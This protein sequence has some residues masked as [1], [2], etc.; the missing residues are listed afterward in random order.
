MPW[1]PPESS[2]P[3]CSSAY[4]SAPF[5]IANEN[6]IIWGTALYIILEIYLLKK[7]K[8]HHDKGSQTDCNTGSM[9]WSRRSSNQ[10]GSVSLV[11]HCPTTF[12]CHISRDWFAVVSPS[13]AFFPISSIPVW[14]H[15]AHVCCSSV[16]VTTG[17]GIGIRCCVTFSIAELVVIAT[18][19]ALL[20]ITMI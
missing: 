20:V 16:R 19:V 7:S 11:I 10:T 12:F 9:V 6:F 2:T 8:H 13:V 15:F 1:E 5:Y 3:S 14:N 4:I 17:I 18:V